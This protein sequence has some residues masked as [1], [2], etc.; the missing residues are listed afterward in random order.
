MASHQVRSTTTAIL[1][2]ITIVIMVLTKIHSV[3]GWTTHTRLSK[4]ILPSSTRI[5]MSSF[6]TTTNN[7]Q[8]HT[9]EDANGD[10]PVYINGTLRIVHHQPPHWLV[11]AKDPGV[12]C[13]HSEFTQS[14][15][16]H[17]APMLQRTRQ[18]LNGQYVNL[19]HRLDR[20]CSGCLLMAYAHTN[21][22]EN[23]TAILPTEEE[24][25]ED[26][27]S[28][29]CIHSSSSSNNNNNS[30]NNPQHIT[31]ALSD[32][33][34]RPQSHKTYIALVRG[35]GILRGRRFQDEGW[36]AVDRPITDLRGKLR[37]ARTW[38]RFIAGQ[39]NQNGTLDRPRASLVLARP[40]TGRWHQIRRH[41]AND[42]SHPIIG[43]SAHGNSKLN[44]EWRQ[45][46]G[47]PG[48]RTCLHLAKLD[49]QLND[50]HHDDD[51]ADD[52]DA[53]EWF[54]NTTNNTTGRL[55]V[56]CPLEDDMWSLLQ[57]HLPDLWKQAQPILAEEGLFL[58]PSPDA[59]DLVRDFSVRVG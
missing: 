52:G 3:R 59:Y 50:N 22:S 9:Q 18:A 43:D 57:N 45:K 58:E 54:T 34:Q 42:L 31:R 8:D 16:Q 7:K 21:A 30:I 48:E 12:V 55:Q 11:V 36:F 20:G 38:F 15:S 35:E 37:S 49:L 4:R 10:T 33:L 13:H 14:K 1:I 40:E 41:L 47:L 39:D 24:N 26:D 28:T 19:I 27:S 56:T 32:A 46:Y 29:S 25:E 2:I 44:R 53:N 5:W 17:E 6:S 23:S 51:E